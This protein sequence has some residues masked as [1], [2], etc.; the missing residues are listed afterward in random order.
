MLNLKKTLVKRFR[1]LYI[2]LALLM[3]TPSVSSAQVKAT[4]DTALF[5]VKARKATSLFEKTAYAKAI[6]LYEE[7]STAGYLPD[8]LQRNLGIAYYKIVDMGKAEPIFKKLVA[9]PSATAPDYYYYSKILKFNGKYDEADVWLDKY[10]A[11][12]ATDQSAQNQKASAPYIKQLL[13]KERYLIAEVPFNSINSDFGAV[14][15]GD[16][17]IFASARPNQDLIKYEDSWKQTPYFAL[18]TVPQ[19]ADTTLPTHFMWKLSTIYHDGPV[20]LNQEQTEMFVTR[21]NYRY[22]LPRKDK[23]G[24]NNL[25][26][27]YTKRSTDGSWG[28]LVELPFNSDSYSCG[29]AALSPDGKTLYFS[30]NMP[31]GYGVTDIYAITRSDSGW[32]APHNLGSDINTEGDEMFPFVGANG[33]L[34]FSSNGHKGIGGLDVFVARLGKNGHYTVKNMGYP[35]NG[36]A[37]DF[38]FYLRPDEKTGYFASNRQGGKGDDDIYAFT[39]TDAIS[40]ALELQ[41]TTADI[42]TK[43]WLTQATVTLKANNPSEAEKVETGDNH[44]F[45]FELEPE[46]TYTITAARQGYTPV[47]IPV[48]PSTMPIVSGVISVPMELRKVDE[49]GVYGNVY[50]KPSME[51]VPEVKVRIE[52]M[53]KTVIGDI[54]TEGEIGFR[55]RLEPETNYVLVFEKKGF[56]TK[57]VDYSTKGR[58]PSYININEIVEIAIEKVELNKTIEIPNIYYDLGKWNI[59]PDAAIELD[60]VVQFLT[61]NPDIKVELASHTDSRG[62]SQANQTLSQKR[63]V[64]AVEYIV[65]KGGI[66]ADR[67]TA[68][69][70]GESKLK[71]QCADGV[72]CSELEHQQNRRTDIR[73]V[74]F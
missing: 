71:N 32:S 37:D 26:I 1:Y 19:N 57:R 12:N 38:S 41:G 59:R 33:L 47:S 72:K 66:S 39:I 50:L 70:Y 56:L 4:L 62:S 46:M 64:S 27:H 73:I 2:L 21:N 51:I 29:H 69:G 48:N 52:K 25:K 43:D 42:D 23:E 8:S 6:Q 34:Y 20:C 9:T 58:R 11:L 18:Y 40:F 16:Q 14:P 65:K 5:K 3:M 55:Q 36:N 67:I 13:E 31:G 35:L 24:V 53:D 45:R 63:A 74:S 60:K 10:L 54:T 17:L 7:L 28:T 15:Y 49:W 68:K 30:S 44:S 61:D 22:L